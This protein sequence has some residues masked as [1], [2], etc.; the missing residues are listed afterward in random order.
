MSQLV[1]VP[2]SAVEKMLSAPLELA[3]LDAAR[4]VQAG[5]TAGAS[6]RIAEGVAESTALRAQI[7]QQQAAPAP[8]IQPAT[9]SASAAPTAPLAA[10]G[11]PPPHGP[12]IPTEMEPGENMGQFYIR[13]ATAARQAAAAPD[14][15]FDLSRPL[16]LR[17]RR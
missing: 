2:M 4:M 9:P 17:S 1:N 8:A 14:G 15:R 7:A 6:R 10:P 13:R 3:R 5:D 11:T 16:G 12:I